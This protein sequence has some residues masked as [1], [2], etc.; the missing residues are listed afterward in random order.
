[1]VTGAVLSRLHNKIKFCCF[2]TCTIIVF[3]TYVFI[4][5]NL[6]KCLQVQKNLVNQ[7][8]IKNL[9][10]FSFLQRCLRLRPLVETNLSTVMV[11]TSQIP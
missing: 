6:L 9:L 8:P 2:F 11:V 10:L 7:Y 1:M 3:F 4:T 5:T